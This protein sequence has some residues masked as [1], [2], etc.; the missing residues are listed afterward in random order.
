VAQDDRVRV[1]LTGIGTLDAVVDYL[2]PNFIGLRT[3]D[4]M[5]RFFGR[6]AWGQP[7]GIS[8]HHFGTGVDEKQLEQAWRTRLDG[9]YA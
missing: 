4:A 1:D 5:V 9:V 8:V 7:V 2:N 6:N 3:A